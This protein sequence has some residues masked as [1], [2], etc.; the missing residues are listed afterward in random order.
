MPHRARSALSHTEIEEIGSAVVKREVDEKVDRNGGRDR[1]ENE[2]GD[3]NDRVSEDVG[4]DLQGR[5]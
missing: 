2:E 3:L 1:E 4:A 5:H